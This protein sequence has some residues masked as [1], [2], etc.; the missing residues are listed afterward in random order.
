MSTAAI[1]E[2]AD[3]IDT[4]ATESVKIPAS[5]LKECMVLMDPETGTPLMW[6]DHKMRTVRNSG[7]VHWMAHNLET[8]RIEEINLFAKLQL[9]VLAA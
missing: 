7:S 3:Q 8:G 5:K 1:I 4:L 9:S 2:N 6:L